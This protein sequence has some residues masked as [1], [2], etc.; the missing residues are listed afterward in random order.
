LRNTVLVLVAFVLIVLGP[1]PADN[2]PYLDSRY[3]RESVGALSAAPMLRSPPGPIRVGVAEAD[4]SPPPGH[5][6]A[7]FSARKES[8]YRDVASPCFARALTVASGD[9][10]VT[11]LTA[12]L[13]LVNAKL[14]RAVL[15]RTG[16]PEAELY[17]TASH[18]HSGPGGWGDHVLEKLVAGP[19]DPRFF[20][21][22]ADQL[23]D[24]VTRSRA[25]L[26][27][28]ELGVVAVPTTG[29]Q[30][31]RLQ[32]DAP[33]DDRLVALAFRQAGEKPGSPRPLLASLVVFSAHATVCGTTNNDLSADY[34]GELV[35][36]L[37]KRTG[38][39][40]VLFAAG[41]VGEAAP[42]RV[43]AGSEQESARL[44]GHALADDL[45]KAM[46][47][48]RFE[49][50]VPLA[51]VRVPIDLPQFRI[52]VGSRW[53]VSPVCSSWVSDRHTHL[54]G[55]RLGP[56]V[57]VGFPGDYS[58]RLAK[59]L[60]EWAAARGLTLVPTSFNG[61]YKG[62]F[63]SERSYMNLRSYETRDMNFFGP[64]AGEYLADLSKRVVERLAP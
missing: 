48:V 26:T 1:W 31:N 11:I 27:L 19:Y 44:L 58:G 43:P 35:A 34:P 52:P 9:T 29:R 18:T 20:N 38:C 4:I 64:W 36:A 46:G 16:L 5:P 24:V 17:F 62:Y 12:D 8:G 6:L 51:A 55:L 2:S 39:P 40:A 32:W 14:A 41:A 54:H 45:A 50:E 28:A 30:T 3:H 21:T 42:F 22:L 33:L 53:R 49:R 59:G 15:D 10:R 37:R 60:A 13:L 23:A 7:G 61:D 56:A 47:G 25:E 57:L 63:V